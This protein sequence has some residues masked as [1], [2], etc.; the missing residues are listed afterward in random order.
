M[1]WIPVKHKL[2]SWTLKFV[3]NRLLQQLLIGEEKENLEN[4]KSFLDEIK[5]IFPF[6]NFLGTFFRQIWK[7][8]GHNLQQCSLCTQNTRR[9]FLSDIAD[10]N[11]WSSRLLKNYAIKKLTQTETILTEN[12]IQQRSNK[13]ESWTTTF[14]GSAG[15]W[16]SIYKQYLTG[17]INETYNGYILKNRL[18]CWRGEF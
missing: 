8:N 12:Y 16:L 5:R 18:M 15:V 14:D 7:N 1:V 9:G 4:K 10:K 11:F 3:F 2:R 6:L 13:K 17:W